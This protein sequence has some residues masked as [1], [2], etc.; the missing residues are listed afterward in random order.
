MRMLTPN[1]G[2]IALLATL[3]ALG[4]FCPSVSADNLD[5]PM[6]F[7]K[8]YAGGN[9]GGSSWTVAQGKIVEE[10]PAVFEELVRSNG[11]RGDGRRI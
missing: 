2:P 7:R 10:T 1:A 5:E 6:R 8:A 3:I 9:S 4:A 11:L